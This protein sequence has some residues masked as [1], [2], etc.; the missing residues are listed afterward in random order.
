MKWRQFIFYRQWHQLKKYCNSSGI[1][2]I[3]DLPFY[4][5]YDSVDVWSDK[6][7]FAIDE[8]GART[9]MAGVPP[10]AFSSDG[11]LWGMPVFNWVALK[12]QQYKWWIERLRK[13]MELFDIIRLDHFRAFASYWEMLPE[14]KQ[15]KMEVGKKPGAHFFSAIEAE[16]GKLP[17][18]AE[19]LGEIDDDVYQLRDQFNMPGMK[20]LQ[21][22][23]SEDMS[24]SPYIPHNYTSNFIVYTGTHDNNT[25]LGWVHQEGKNDL[26][27]LHNY[28][29]YS[30][31]ENELPDV[32]AR[33][34]YSSVARLAI[35]PIQ[36][37]LGLDENARMNVPS[38]G[39]DNWSW[40]LLPNQFN[41]NAEEKLKYWTTLYNRE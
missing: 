2:L 39:K 12:E 15:L 36:D 7:L 14:N 21:F 5:S 1:K 26:Q 20:V 29:G 24:I 19:D 3:G 13:N 35:L 37:V 4:I 25:M 17:F 9:G 23:F 28:L 41:T 32:M 31:S 27:R 10:D 38:Q 40:R 18:I 30:V 33:L 16:F 34:A 8:K 22:A 11:Q 6:E